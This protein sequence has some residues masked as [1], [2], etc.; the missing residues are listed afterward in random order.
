MANL[1]R[2][3]ITRISSQ[4]TGKLSPSRR[5]LQVPISISFE[6][7]NNT[8]RLS[9]KREVL[10]I[11]GETKDLS[12]NGIAFLVDSIRLREY[13]LVGED[14][15]LDANL[16]LPGAKVRMKVLGRR[17][18]LVGEN[19]SVNKYLIGATIESMNQLDREIYEDYLKNGNKFKN[20]KSEIFEFEAS[21]S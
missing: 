2:K 3:I 5:D 7:E 9:M 1:I 15:I 14:R 20:R 4:I 12:S 13:Y 8:G 11:R 16:E 19:L 21:K 6:P 17:Y 10:S 18:E